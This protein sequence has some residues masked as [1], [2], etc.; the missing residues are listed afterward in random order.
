MAYDLKTVL[1]ACLACSLPFSWISSGNADETTRPVAVRIMEQGYGGLFLVTTANSK[2][3]EVYQRVDTPLG[4]SADANVVCMPRECF[5]EVVPLPEA[6]IARYEKG[7]RA[8]N[9]LRQRLNAIRDTY[10]ALRSAS[11]EARGD[12]IGKWNA[13]TA[14]LAQ[15]LTREDECR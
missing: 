11:P 8:I 15:C 5:L 1:T 2:D 10:A 4:I 3:Y 12:A 7:E 14:L 6:T 13:A 9:G